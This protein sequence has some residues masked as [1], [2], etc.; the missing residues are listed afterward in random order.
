M[1]RNGRHSERGAAA[2]EFALVLTPLLLLVL[3]TIDWGYYFYVREVV[4]NAAREGARAGSIN[5]TTGAA[6]AN[7]YLT[8]AGLSPVAAGCAAPPA[9]ASC[10]QINY[11]TGS[12]TGFLAGVMPATASALATMR[13]EPAAGP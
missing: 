11:S 9:N 10:V 8:L 7:G 1:R 12:I 4:T 2:V 5:R 3:G 13:W 6:D